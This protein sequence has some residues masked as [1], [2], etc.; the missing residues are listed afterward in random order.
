MPA[1]AMNM[2][3]FA[4]SRTRSNTFIVNIAFQFSCCNNC[5]EDVLTDSTEEVHTM[6]SSA[7]NVRAPI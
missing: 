3:V 1:S 2:L 5:T 6:C 7:T 4:S